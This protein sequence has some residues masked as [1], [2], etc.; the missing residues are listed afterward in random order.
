MERILLAYRGCI[1]LT[2][3]LVTI[4]TTIVQLYSLS[5]E[6][7]EG[8]TVGTQGGLLRTSSLDYLA[9]SCDIITNPIH[10]SLQGNKNMYM[11]CIS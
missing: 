4:N 2:I 3:T 10:R 5:T 8:A 9:A 11:Y 6:Q 7:V 1:T